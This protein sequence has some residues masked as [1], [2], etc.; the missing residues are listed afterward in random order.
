MVCSPALRHSESTVDGEALPRDRVGRV[1]S[2]EDA[3]LSEVVDRRRFPQ[4]RACGDK[5]EHF[6]GG[7]RRG[8]C[9]LK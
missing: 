7:Q 4:R 3:R 2:E 9:R 6:L 1:G 8:V 5:A